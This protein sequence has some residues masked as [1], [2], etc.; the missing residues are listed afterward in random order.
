MPL[1][2]NER[3]IGCFPDSLQWI[4]RSFDTQGMVIIYTLYTPPAPERNI[5][6]QHY[7]HRMVRTYRPT[8]AIMSDTTVLVRDRNTGRIA[9]IRTR[10]EPVKLRVCRACRRPHPA[11]C[12][13]AAR[14][15]A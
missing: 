2:G 10:L 12:Q 6:A 14:S 1:P 4:A 7:H 9:R 3:R 11:S 8:E 15:A 13:Q 5:P